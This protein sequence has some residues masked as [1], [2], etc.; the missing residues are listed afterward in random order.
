MMYELEQDLY[1]L[2]LEYSNTFNRDDL[3]SMVLNITEEF[4]NNDENWSI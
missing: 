4:V 1:I 3:K 2:L